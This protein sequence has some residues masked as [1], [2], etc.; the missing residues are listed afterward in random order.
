MLEMRE[1]KEER[2]RRLFNSKEFNQFP[3]K[4]SL[5]FLKRV[6]MKKLETR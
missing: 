6:S 5:R 4:F 2:K 1:F 3:M